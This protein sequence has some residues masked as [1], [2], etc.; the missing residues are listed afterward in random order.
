MRYTVILPEGGRGFSLEGARAID[1]TIAGH[2]MVRNAAL[3]ANRLTIEE[4]VSSA[5]G[6]L[7]ADEVRMARREAARLGAGALRLNAPADTIRRWRFAG[8]PDRSAL[9]PLE[10]AYAARIEQDPGAVDQIV[11]RARFRM[12]T[13]DFTG[14]LADFDRALE[15]ERSAD[16]LVARSQAWAELRNRA[17]SRDDLAEAYDLD[18]DPWRALPLADA[19]AETGDPDGAVDLLL[20]IDGDEE[21]RQAVKNTLADAHALAGDVQGGLAYIDEVLSTAPNDPQSLNSKCWFM[22]RYGLDL[23]D[24]LPIC[25]RAVESADAPA[26]ALDSRALVLLRLGQLDEALADAEAALDLEPGLVPTE[27]VRGLILREM[28]NREAEA[29]IRGA[30]ARSPAI[31]PV[32]QRM[33]FDLGE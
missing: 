22:G 32:Y 10:A 16:L 20:Q 31:T 25:T 29:I 26:A 23:D 13:Y 4:Q 33:G 14:A 15:L 21:L 19:M 8:S 11:N 27:L 1:T 3:D 2:H 28:G 7:A 24:A 6:T 18:P 9:A 12:D 30:L 5:G 17:R